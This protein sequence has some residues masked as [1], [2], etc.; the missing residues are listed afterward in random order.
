VFVHGTLGDYR[1]WLPQLGVFSEQFRVL[2]YSR[3]YHYPN[4][5]DS[6]RD[7]LDYSAALHAN[8]LAALIDA[9][10][11]G[12]VHVVSASYGSYVA[13]IHALSHPS[14]V[15]S[16]VVGE[17]PMLDWLAEMEGGEPLAREFVKRTLKP[18]YDALQSG[19]IEEGIREFIDGVH[20]VHGAFDRFTPK[21][22]QALLDNGPEIQAESRSNRLF[23]PFGCNDAA[24]I[25]I[26]ILLLTGARSPALFRRITDELERCLPNAERVTIPAV[27]HAMN[28]ARP[29]TYNEIVL[30][31]LTRV[32]E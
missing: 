14:Q 2:S 20:G 29:R 7:G 3:R 12:P 23:P 31:F 30:R 1:S 26:P 25:A 13:L 18:A 4:A 5:W 27:S 22:R 19:Q 16:L 6:G 9:V 11:G 24:R 15:R 10:V 28:A 32:E 17:P 21:V 8:D